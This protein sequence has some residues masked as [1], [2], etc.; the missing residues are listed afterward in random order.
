MQ[1]SYLADGEL[2]EAGNENQLFTG[3]KNYVKIKKIL[4]LT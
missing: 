4:D 3:D 1:H 2:I